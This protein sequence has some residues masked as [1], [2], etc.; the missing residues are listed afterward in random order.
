MWQNLLIA[1]SCA[2]LIL[3]FARFYVDFEI[4]ITRSTD[5]GFNFRVDLG[6]KKV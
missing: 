4:S 6:I 1:V 3:L 2:S 5:G